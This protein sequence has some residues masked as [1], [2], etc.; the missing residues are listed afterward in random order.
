MGNSTVA[1]L[2]LFFL[3]SHFNSSSTH[4]LA[5]GLCSEHHDELVVQPNS[6]IDALADLVTNLQIL[7]RQP[8]PN[9]LLTKITI[10]LA[11]KLLILCAVGDDT[12]IK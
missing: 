4:V 8:A 1:T 3:K 2:F 5:Y 9:V 7:G 10:Q 11:S 6:I 12:R